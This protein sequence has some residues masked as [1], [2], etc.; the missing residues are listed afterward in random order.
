VR[1]SLRRHRRLLEAVRNRQ[2][3]PGTGVSR[4]GV[5]PLLVD[6]GRKAA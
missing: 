4:S 6:D 2:P 5:H 3:D 1:R